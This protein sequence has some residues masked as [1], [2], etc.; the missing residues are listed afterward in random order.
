MPCHGS[1][2]TRVHPCR[3]P[4]LHV[5]AS[6]PDP[7]TLRYFPAVL[8]T[9]RW[10]SAMS[11]QVTHLL[12]LPRPR[13][14]ANSRP[15]NGTPVAADRGVIQAESA[16]RITPRR[17]DA[18]TMIPLQATCS[19]PHHKPSPGRS[20]RASASRLRLP[21]STSSPPTGAG[22]QRDHSGG[23]GDRRSA[24]M[25]ARAEGSRH[26]AWPN[27]LICSASSAVSLRGTSPCA[28]FSAWT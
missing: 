2:S 24:R 13:T 20:T 11:S 26:S 12:H 23:L 17:S 27:I 6:P 28:T 15:T 3:S 1:T 5:P 9:V 25:T 14:A 22:H 10:A 4:S 16:S 18:R 21:S 8:T 7:H 19:T